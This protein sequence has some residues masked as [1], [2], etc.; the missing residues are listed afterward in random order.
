MANLV[1]TLFLGISI[2]AAIAAHAIA[3]Q[4][5]CTTLWGFATLICARHLRLGHANHAA[6][7]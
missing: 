6:T 7:D 1:L 2:L 3:Q 5:R 4:K